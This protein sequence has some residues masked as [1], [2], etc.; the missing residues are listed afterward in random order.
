MLSRQ[1]LIPL[2][3]AIILAVAGALLLFEQR[4]TDV[5]L[6]TPAAPLVFDG[7]S[8]MRFAQAQCD[9]GP[10]PTGSAKGKQTGDYIV[11]QLKS[12]GWAVEEQTFEYRKTPIRNLIAKRGQ[13]PITI[14]GAHY[15][16]RPR[17]DRDPKDPASPI[18]GANDGASGVAV[19]L[20]LARVLPANPGKQVWLAF[21]D[22]EDWGGIDG[23]P[24]SVGADYLAA[25]LKEKPAAVIVLDMIGDSD[26]QIYYETNSNAPIQQAIFAEADR[27]GYRANFIPEARYSMTDDHTPFLQRGYPAVDLIDFD[28]PYWH[29]L[30]DTC[31]KISGMSMEKVG[32][33]IAAWLTA[34][35]AAP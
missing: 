6:A 24:F 8:A 32:R 31:D 28:Y 9:I 16:T 21:F 25:S 5:P 1:H 12:M 33:T 17:A 3:L 19:L 18:V 20:E 13:G 10:R 29:T 35:K 14:I 34:P 22:A 15:D 11:S 27:L 26:L 2:A 4:A 7:G 30:A 23:W